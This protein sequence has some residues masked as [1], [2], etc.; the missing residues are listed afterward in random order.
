MNRITKVAYEG[1]SA[2]VQIAE[3]IVEVDFD[4][5]PY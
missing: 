1:I 3:M 2:L 4:R 5:M